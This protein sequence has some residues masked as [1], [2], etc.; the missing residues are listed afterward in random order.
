MSLLDQLPDAQRKDYRRRAIWTSIGDGLMAA[1]GR[2]PNATSGLM[3]QAE[4]LLDAQLKR[5]E[6]EDLMRQA[7]NQRA[8]IHGLLEAG[9]IDAPTKLMLDKMDP[10]SVAEILT[11][12]HDPYTLS[13][14]QGRY[15]GLSP[16]PIAERGPKAPEH[17]TLGSGQTRFNPDGTPIAALDTT[18]QRNVG[19]PTESETQREQNIRDAMAMPRFAHLR[20]DPALLRQA[21]VDYVSRYPTSAVMQDP[22]TGN[23]TSIDRSAPGYSP[24]HLPIQGYE[25]PPIAPPSS[26]VTD[27][28]HLRIDPGLGTGAWATIKMRWNDTLGQIPGFKV[29]TNEAQA[30]QSLRYL[31]R[32][33]INAFRSSNRP[34]VIE[35]ER[36]TRLF[37]QPEM[38]NQ[39]PRLARDMLSSAV[40][41]MAEQYRDDTAFSNAPGI[42]R[43]EREQA[44]T[45]ARDMRNM[46][47]RVVTPDHL[48]RLIGGGQEPGIPDDISDIMRRYGD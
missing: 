36:I 3:G 19:L 32:D 40:D 20:N 6:R 13:A 43:A 35:Q 14:E 28:S 45:R 33:A 48:E 17:F 47:G 22:N 8:G 23:L 42:S 46:M 16:N 1:G 18:E 41:I 5:Q 10:K 26:V 9:Y 4:G 12:A 37:P 25:A 21:A 11:K 15:F 24:T 7:A 29:F 2:T 31:E 39:N 38:W 30:A 44:R 34:P 27:P